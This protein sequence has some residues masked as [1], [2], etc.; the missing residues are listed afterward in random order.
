MLGL[1]LGIL[2]GVYIENGQ[3]EKNCKSYCQRPCPWRRKYHVEPEQH[4]QQPSTNTNQHHHDRP[5]PKL[6]YIMSKL[7]KLKPCRKGYTR[8]LTTDSSYSS[9]LSCAMASMFLSLSLPPLVSICMRRHRQS[10]TRPRKT[11]KHNYAIAAFIRKIRASGMLLI[12]LSN[13]AIDVNEVSRVTNKL[14]SQ[15]STKTH[16]PRGQHERNWSLRN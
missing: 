4:Q 12:L 8:Y 1:A 2:G 3:G 5:R 16:E 10:G 13:T 7:G 9:F 15:I 14:R 6:E 11:R